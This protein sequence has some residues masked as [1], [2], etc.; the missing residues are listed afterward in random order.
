MNNMHRLNLFQC[1]QRGIMSTK[2]QLFMTRVYFLYNILYAR[3]HLNA[4][5]DMFLKRESE[6]GNW[7]RRDNYFLTRDNVDPIVFTR[8]IYVFFILLLCSLLLLVGYLY[9]ALL[10]KRLAAGQE[11]H[12]G[13]GATALYCLPLRV[14]VLFYLHSVVQKV[15]FVL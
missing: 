13:K 7:F 10:E 11:Q 14:I 1:T 5:N 3:T 8:Y 4:V 15:S 6:W 12:R 9:C 2:N